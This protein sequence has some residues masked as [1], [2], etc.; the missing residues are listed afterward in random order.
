[1]ATAATQKAE[2]VPLR[3]PEFMS[4]PL[5]GTSSG[6]GSEG[7]DTPV[8]KLK[9]FAY[10]TFASTK[11][12]VKT[13]RSWVE[14][15]DVR[16]ARVPKTMGQATSHVRANW[17]HF[18]VNYIV[19]MTAVMTVTMLLRSFYSFSLCVFLALLWSWVVWLRPNAE[20]SLKVLG[21]EYSPTE[22]RVLLGVG[23]FI[24]IFFFSNAA[25]AAFT[26]F[27]FG[28]AAVVA[29]GSLMDRNDMF[30]ADGPDVEAGGPSVDAIGA[31]GIVMQ[32]M[33]TSTKS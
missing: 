4:A 21:K 19:V 27:L 25:S 30:D 33:F 6:S 14:F 32:N 7:D 29:H 11:G 1:M 8:A 28:A 12:F 26:A 13:A 17:K 3:T 24:L 18:R 10:N 23:S 5:G 15:F 22:Q 2:E 31:A 16:Q 9:R 20:G